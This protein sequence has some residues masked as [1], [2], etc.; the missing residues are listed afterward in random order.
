MTEEQKNQRRLTA[1]ERLARKAERLN[2][3]A[4]EVKREQRLVNEKKRKER[5]RKLI[6]LGGLFEIARLTE[7]DRGVLMGALLEIQEQIN[8]PQKSLLWKKKGDATLMERA[9]KGAKNNDEA[10]STEGATEG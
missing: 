3:L 7:E 8:D 1:E 5:T 6:E 10:S 4:Q 9:Q 2:K